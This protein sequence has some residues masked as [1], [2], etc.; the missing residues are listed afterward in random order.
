MKNLSKALSAP[1]VMTTSKWRAPPNQCCCMMDHLVYCGSQGLCVLCMA[2]RQLGVAMGRQLVP[3]FQLADA[4]DWQKLVSLQKWKSWLPVW[5]I[6]AWHHL[7]VSWEIRDSCS[8][9]FGMSM[10]TCHTF[11]QVEERLVMFKLQR[12]CDLEW[13]GGCSELRTSFTP[14]GSFQRWTAFIS[15]FVSDWFI[16]IRHSLTQAYI[17]IINNFNQLET[18]W[19]PSVT[20]DK[21]EIA[22]YFT[23]INKTI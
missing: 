10:G 12:K 18:A 7:S 17:K 20:E 15:A 16:G 8:G 9:R 5:V 14:W 21:V 2:G 11:L 6:A 22:I 3:P 13:G 19:N 4:K 1:P 23:R